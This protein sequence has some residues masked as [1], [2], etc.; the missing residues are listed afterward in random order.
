MGVTYRL[1]WSDIARSLSRISARAIGLRTQRVVSLAQRSASRLTRVVTLGT[2][3]RWPYCPV[4][5]FKGAAPFGH[6]R[7]ATERLAVDAVL[8]RIANARSSPRT[9]ISAGLWPLVV[10]RHEGGSNELPKRETALLQAF[11]VDGA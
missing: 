3:R 8:M 9:H 7:G 11:F 1:L 4:A 10:P 5:F 2:E 6:S